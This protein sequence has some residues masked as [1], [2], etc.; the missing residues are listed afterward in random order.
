[1]TEL[2]APY[3]YYILPAS[4]Q[5]TPTDRFWNAP[6]S[7]WM[8]VWLTTGSGTQISGLTY[9]RPIP[10]PE[11]FELR[12]EGETICH[13]DM[14]CRSA[15]SP[16]RNCLFSHLLVSSSVDKRAG[17]V[18]IKDLVFFR[19]KAT[20]RGPFEERRDNWRREL[21]LLNRAHKRTLLTLSDLRVA[22][23]LVSDK[24]RYVTA[25]RDTALERCK[26]LLQQLRVADMMSGQTPGKV[27]SITAERD[28]YI[29][30]CAEL[31]KRLAAIREIVK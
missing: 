29:A 23:T 6:R 14:M 18:D 8:S 20:Q 26:D 3:G 17:E 19:P 30:R 9:V 22:H 5:V 2:K 25:D 31:E 21:E 11:G 15:P 28:R 1:M 13:G 7:R 24:L 10:A 16:W 4:E 12:P 27:S